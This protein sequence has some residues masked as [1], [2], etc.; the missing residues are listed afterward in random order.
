MSAL[1]WT[2][3][4][5]HIRLV[6][7]IADEGPH[8]AFADERVPVGK[9]RH[10]EQNATGPALPQRRDAVIE[11]LFELLTEHGKPLCVFHGVGAAAHAVETHIG[12]PCI[13][14][15]SL[16][17]AQQAFL[18]T[19]RAIAPRRSYDFATRAFPFPLAF[20]STWPSREDPLAPSGV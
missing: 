11:R 17:Q 15:S 16:N 9:H 2:K 3:M 7:K 20:A 10:L 13:Q 18:R 1:R 19:V 6:L 8:R 14:L 4:F 12:A 5:V